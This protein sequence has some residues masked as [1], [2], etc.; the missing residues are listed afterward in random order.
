MRFRFC[1]LVKEIKRS[2]PGQQKHAVPKYHQLFDFGRPPRITKEF[3]GEFQ[4]IWDILDLS[5]TQDSGSS[6][7]ICR[8]GN[9]N[10]NL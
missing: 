8:L 2:G 5:P 4:E 10:L 7:P 9:P 1:I 6:P 3:I